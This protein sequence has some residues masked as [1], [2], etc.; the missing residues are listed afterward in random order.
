MKTNIPI[1]SVGKAGASLLAAMT[2]LAVAS[3][4]IAPSFRSSAGDSPS[5]RL[6]IEGEVVGEFQD[7]EGIS[8]ETEVVEFREG[9][10]TG[11][12]LHLP[13]RTTYSVELQR[14]IIPGDLLWQWRQ[15]VIDGEL[16]RR[17]GAIV[18]VD[19]QNRIIARYHFFDAW[20][21]KWNAVEL[22]ATDKHRAI[23]TFQLVAER[24]ELAE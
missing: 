16:D 7:L 8:S 13:G 5:F 18:V 17:N 20:P 12:I 24:I 19:E 11:G 9:S 6:E 14:G 21:S 15:N 10:D 23:E 22:E 2:V 3:V 1:N 4:S